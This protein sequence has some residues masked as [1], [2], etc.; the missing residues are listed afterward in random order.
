MATAWI[1]GVL[2]GVIQI[3]GLAFRPFMFMIKLKL[4][5]E[6]L[7]VVIFYFHSWNISQRIHASVLVSFGLL[8]VD[9]FLRVQNFDDIW[10]RVVVMWTHLQLL[11]YK[12]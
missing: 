12:L 7:K 2:N 6:L 3:A 8:L 11:C 5:I 9:G 1:I 4:D 10:K